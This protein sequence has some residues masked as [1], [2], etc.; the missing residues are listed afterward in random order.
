[1]DELM[2]L[3]YRRRSL[4]PTGRIHPGVCMP[5]SFLASCTQIDGD[6]NV[7]AFIYRQQRVGQPIR[8]V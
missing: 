5:L 8:F 6:D 3:W 1:M 2:G 7:T 4:G